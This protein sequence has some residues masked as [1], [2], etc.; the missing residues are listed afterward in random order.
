MMSGKHLILYLHKNMLDKCQSLISIASLLPF[1]FSSFA[2]SSLSP[3]S[4]PS[5]HAKEHGSRLGI[6]EP[7]T[8][9]TLAVCLQIRCAHFT[10]CLR[11]SSPNLS[12]RLLATGSCRALDTS[13]IPTSASVTI[14]SSAGASG[15]P[16]LP[17]K[18]HWIP[19]L[20]S[21]HLPQQEPRPD[22]MKPTESFA[23][24][25]LRHFWNNIQE[26]I[27]RGYHWKR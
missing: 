15:C 26:T 10:C 13:V 19:E 21:L 25:F 6:R 24:I 7:H 9:Q 11:F 23:F 27:A 18:R 3:L 14:A 20:P 5:P 17:W 12:L 4:R 16:S 8:C 2:F 1:T 22:Y